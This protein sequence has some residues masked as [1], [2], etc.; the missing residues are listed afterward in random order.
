MQCPE[1][2]W[3]KIFEINVKAAF[4]LTKEVKPHLMGRKGSNI[5][6][7]SSIAG[8]QPFSVFQPYIRTF[9]YIYIS[10]I[11]TTFHLHKQ[12]LGPYSVSKTALL[13]LTKIMAQELGPENIR[14]NCVAPGIIKTRFSSAVSS[15]ASSLYG[16]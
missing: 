8:F 2:A 13:G 6:Y 14:V 9:L 11:S 1:D 7:V 10:I 15:L 4:L 3:D 5:V 16:A 12:V